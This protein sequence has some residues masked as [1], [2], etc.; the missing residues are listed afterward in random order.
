M[1]PLKADAETFIQNAPFNLSENDKRVLRQQPGSFNLHTWD[2]V[3]G[4]VGNISSRVTELYSILANMKLTAA[5]DISSLV[6]TPVDTRKYLLF[7]HETGKKHGSVAQYVQQHRLH[8]WPPP[9]QPADPVPFANPEDYKILR[10]DWPYGVTPDI[11]HMVVWSKARLNVVAEKGSLT[12]ASWDLVQQFID[13]TFG[14]VLG[15]N[16]AEKLIWFKQN[17]K[18]QSVKALEHIH[19]IVR[20]VEEEVIERWTGQSVD[21]IHARNWMPQSGTS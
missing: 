21:D 8:W 20:G 19:V 9:V 13:R 5:G 11:T 4:L 1:D 10:N 2:E 15:D 16:A 7:Y 3:K 6:R 18:W 14:S 17:A 12:Q